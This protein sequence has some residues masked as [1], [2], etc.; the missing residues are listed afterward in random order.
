MFLTR[1]DGT[2]YD[3]LYNLVG[4]NPIL[5]PLGVVALFLLYIVAFYAVYYAVTR[6]NKADRV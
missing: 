2:P 4:G 6:R 5:Y 1:G 3:L